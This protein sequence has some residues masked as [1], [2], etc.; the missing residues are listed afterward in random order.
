MVAHD[1]K[2]WWL[3]CDAEGCGA[4]ELLEAAGRRWVTVQPHRG[5]R[6]GDLCPRHADGRTVRLPAQLPALPVEMRT[7]A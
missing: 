1:G 7:Q 3:S 5:H 6:H 2:A 4:V